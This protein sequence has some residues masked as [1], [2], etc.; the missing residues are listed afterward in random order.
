MKWGISC[1]VDTD[2][3]LG[4]VLAVLKSVGVHITGYDAIGKSPKQTTSQRKASS[5]G[6]NSSVVVLRILAKQG[7]PMS[8]T[9][10]RKRFGVDLPGRTF[11]SSNLTQL[12]GKGIIKQPKPKQWQITPK[13]KAAI[14]EMEKGK[15]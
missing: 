6:E 9:D 3:Q 8:T 12:K 2:E 13:G 4:K 11:P 7:R 1:E 14:V 15:E 10:L 5:G